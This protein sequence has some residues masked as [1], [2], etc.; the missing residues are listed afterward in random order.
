MAIVSKKAFTDPALQW[1]P[2]LRFGMCSDI[3]RQ[4]I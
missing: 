2:E 4:W 3:L 1:F